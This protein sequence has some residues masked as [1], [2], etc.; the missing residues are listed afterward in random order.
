M[1]IAGPASLLL[2]GLVCVISAI[3]A[4]GGKLGPWQLAV[5]KTLFRQVMLG[6]LGLVLCG[7]AAVWAL[8]NERNKVFHVE[9]ATLDAEGAVYTGPCP[10]RV[11]FT[12]NIRTSGGHGGTVAYRFV[13]KTGDFTQDLLIKEFKEP[14]AQPVDATR[15]VRTDTES[16]A[17]L[18]I[19]SPDPHQS[20]RVPF[21]VVCTGPKPR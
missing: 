10:H 20:R 2:L 8:R 5:V 3:V 14:G 16:T 11:R 9:R 21:R 6:L 15:V 17:Y 13:D 12:G 19:Y 7:V 4:G 18:K 1:E